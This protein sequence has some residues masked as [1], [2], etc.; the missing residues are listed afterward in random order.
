MEVTGKSVNK[1]TYNDFEVWRATSQDLEL[2]AKEM[3]A[4]WSPVPQ[5]DPT[6]TMIGKIKM[7]T[8]QP[9]ILK[10]DEVRKMKPLM[11]KLVEA[12][13]VYGVYDDQD[14]LLSSKITL[15][16]G[17]L[18]LHCLQAQPPP[19]H[20]SVLLVESIKPRDPGAFYEPYSRSMS[21]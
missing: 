2:L 21:S 7:I 6:L 10:F 19:D 14:H 15:R 12:G 9:E 18:Y 11:K 4:S 8:T 17:K 13:Q 20:A 1:E 3:S 16:N 5:L